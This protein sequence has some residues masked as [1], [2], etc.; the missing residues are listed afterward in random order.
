MFIVSSDEPLSI[1]ITSL[2]LTLW[3]NT[4]LI[5]LFNKRHLLSVGITTETVSKLFCAFIKDYIS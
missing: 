4:E 5:A 1:T 3:F 2:G